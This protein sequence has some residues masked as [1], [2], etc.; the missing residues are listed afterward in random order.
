M[1]PAQPAPGDTA[2]VTPATAPHEPAKP[3][4]P[5]KLLPFV[6]K[7]LGDPRYD[8]YPRKDWRRGVRSVLRFAWLSVFAV[9]PV[10]IIY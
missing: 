10:S 7:D 6:D 8:R 5:A 3:D 9:Y 4:I 1:P 2:T